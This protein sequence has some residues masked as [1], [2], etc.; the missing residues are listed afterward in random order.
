MFDTIGTGKSG[1]P[2]VLSELNE[3]EKAALTDI[4]WSA[5]RALDAGVA[6]HGRRRNDGMRNMTA[7]LRR[8]HGIEAD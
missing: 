4:L 3:Y 2:L 8:V 6:N 5:E 1:A 7:E